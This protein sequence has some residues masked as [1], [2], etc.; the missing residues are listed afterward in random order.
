MLFRSKAEKEAKAKEVQAKAAQAKAAQAKAAQAKA[1]QAEAAQAEAAQAE[2]DNEQ[3]EEDNT[4]LEMKID[5]RDR[6]LMERFKTVKKRYERLQVL[7]GNNRIVKRFK[8]GKCFY[9]NDYY[10]EY[11]TRCTKHKRKLAKI[12]KYFAKRERR[13][14][15]N[16]KYSHDIANCNVRISN[17]F[18][19]KCQNKFNEISKSLY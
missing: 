17:E 19:D 4:P 2:T 14:Y 9:D 12:I 10:N 13:N 7:K 5:D 16:T 8:P 6:R 11:S 1:A 15:C 18:R 3:N